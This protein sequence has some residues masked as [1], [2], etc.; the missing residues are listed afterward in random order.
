MRHRKIGRKLGRN[1]NHQR[2]LLRSL[3]VALILTERETEDYDSEKQA[4]KV[5][6]RIITTIT[7]AK[8]VRPF[9]ERCVT[10]AIKAQK[11]ILE[12]EKLAPKADRQ[13][14]AWRAWREGEGWKEWVKVAAP[15][16]A[17]RRRVK[18]LL[19]SDEAV[20]I[21]FEK[22]APRY[23]DRNGG[24]TRIVRL[25]KPRLGDSGVRAILEFVGERDRE[26]KA[27]VVP[28]VESK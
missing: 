11:S 27:P 21:L 10:L 3:T 25:A 6:G 24:Y 12:A 2:A 22:I 1:P 17:Y 20:S 9:V 16:L 15:G 13:S 5:K 18:Q 23:T 4:A 8:E 14:A 28:S 19:G 26:N 7:K